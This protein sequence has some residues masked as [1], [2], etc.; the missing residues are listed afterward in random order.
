MPRWRYSFV[1]AG[2]YK[3]VVEVNV[4]GKITYQSHPIRIQV[5]TTWE[6]PVAIIEPQSLV[7]IKGDTAT[8]KSQSSHDK[9]TA[10]SLLWM[11][12]NGGNAKS[13][14]YTIDT[15]DWE[16]GEYWVS[17]RVKDEQGFENTDKAQLIVMEE[18]GNVDDIIDPTA[19]EEIPKIRPEDIRLSLSASAYHIAEGKP[20]QFTITQQPLTEAE[21][22]VVFGDNEEKSTSESWL[23]H[24][25][26]QFGSYSA[27]V[28]MS[29]QQQTIRSKE[30]KIWVW[31][32]WLIIGLVGVGLLLLSGLFKLFKPKIKK[33]ISTKTS[34]VSYEPLVDVGEQNLELESDSNAKNTEISFI[35]ER[36]EGKQRMVYDTE[37]KEK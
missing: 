12:E 35:A 17:L 33:N 1:N 22:R 19:A 23:E 4:A 13:K 6:Q 15:R 25:Y 24:P 14:S 29:Y 2:T 26:N 34:Y 18:G 31:P 30:I 9:K 10:I 37:D 20:I 16:V 8:F 3:V 5:A 21:Y 36:D 27:Y 32:S 7:V 28:E 11:D